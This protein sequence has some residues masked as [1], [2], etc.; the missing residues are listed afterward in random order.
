M[1][2][3]EGS[4]TKMKKFYLKLLAFSL[5]IGLFGYLSLPAAAQSNGL[6]VTPR[7][8]LGSRPGGVIRDSLRVSNLSTTQPLNLRISV[9][10]FRPA[11]ESGTPQL[12][13]DPNAEQT[14]WSLKP[15]LTI[16]ETATVGAGQSTNIPFTVRFPENVGA[17]SY[18]SAIEYQA[19]GATD[20]QRV[21]IAASSATLLFINVQGDAQELLTLLDFGPSSGG[22]IKSIFSESPQTFQYR[23]KN[24]GNLN[25]APAGS[26][27]VK[28][29]MGKIIASIDRVNPRG[30]LALIGQTRRFETCYP[31]NTE[32][33]ELVKPDNCQPL[34]LMP[35]RYTAEIVLLYGQNGQQTREIGAKAAFWYLPPWFVAFLI[36][37]LAA[38][39]W[40]VYTIYRRRKPR[41]RR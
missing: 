20:E 28:N 40:V 34:N 7:I 24:S 19:V 8:S 10:D 41:R 33:S 30:E 4:K 16:P 1:L 39:A 38:I 13:R 31:R 25:E 27:V 32:E 15:Y 29:M 6:G 23:L 2:I 11:G 37:V 21:N 3:R 26:I 18:Y 35:G 22:K 5:A 14:P 12:I 9:I 36:V 17:G